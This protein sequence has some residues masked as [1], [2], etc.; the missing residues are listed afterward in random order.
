MPSGM[1]STPPRRIGPGRPKGSKDRVPRSFKSGV[2]AAYERIESDD[3]QLIERAI[4]AGLEGK[5]PFPWVSLYAQY[6]ASKPK[7][8]VELTGKD[9][10]PLT[11]LLY[12]PDNQRG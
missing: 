4:R 7:E 10:D 5:Q 12:L 6:T 1:N 11:V 9:G 8:R 2:I 3:P